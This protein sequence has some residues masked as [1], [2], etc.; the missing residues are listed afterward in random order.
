MHSY[1]AASISEDRLNY[2]KI[3]TLYFMWPRPPLEEDIYKKYSFLKGGIYLPLFCD[4]Y[5]SLTNYSFFP[6]YVRQGF[7][8]GPH[9]GRC[10]DGNGLLSWATYLNLLSLEAITTATSF[11]MPAVKRKSIFQWTL[12]SHFAFIS[13]QW[14]WIRGW[15]QFWLW[16]LSKS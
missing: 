5:A 6:T 3:F 15:T 12:P 16:I 1:H 4:L 13:S 14:I 7:Q 11:W 2:V 9:C 10:R 8:A